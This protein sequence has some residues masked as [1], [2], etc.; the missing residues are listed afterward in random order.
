MALVY[1]I[2][3]FQST[4]VRL[5]KNQFD[6]NTLFISKIAEFSSM[7][8]TRVK[9]DKETNKTAKEDVSIIEWV[10]QTPLYLEWKRKKDEE[11]SNKLSRLTYYKQ[12]AEEEGGLGSSGVEDSDWK[13]LIGS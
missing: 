13:N 10:K 12:K 4:M 2:L 6:V 5:F 3:S 11:E 1:R 7:K 9:I 8:A